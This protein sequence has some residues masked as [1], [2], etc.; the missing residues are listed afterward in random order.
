[1]AEDVLTVP[2]QFRVQADWS[3]RLGS[4]LYSHLLSQAADDY[5]AG[6]PVRELLEPLAHDLRGIA[7]PLQLMAAVHRLVLEGRAPELARFYPSAG[8]SLAIEASWEPFRS[9]MAEQMDRVAPAGEPARSNQRPGALRQPAGRISADRP[10][11]RPALASARNRL[12]RRPKPVLGSIPLRM[13]Q[14]RLGGW[15]DPASPLRLEDV[16]VEGAPPSAAVTV[17]ERSG[18]DPDPVDVHSPEG[19]LTLLACTWPDQL[20]RIRRLEAA[21]GIARSLSYLVERAGAA[22]WLEAR[23]ARPAAGAAT[24]VFHSVVWPYLADSERARVT[25]IIEEAGQAA[26][27]GRAA[28][29]VENGA[30]NRDREEPEVRLRIYPGFDRARHRNYALSMGPPSDGRWS[31]DQRKKGEARG[32]RASPFLRAASRLLEVQAHAELHDAPAGIVGVRKIPVRAGRLAEAGAVHGE[33][34]G[35]SAARNEQQE[36]RPVDRVQRLHAELQVDALGDPGLLHQAEVPLL[37]RRPVEEDSL[38]E[39]A[40]LIRGSDVRRARVE[41]LPT[42][43]RSP[44]TPRSCCRSATAAGS[45]RHRAPCWSRWRPGRPC[46]STSCP[47]AGWRSCCAESRRN[48]S[49]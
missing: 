45:T 28:G 4:P 7:L 25:G 11:H 42:S 48:R 6:G 32:S 34:R 5:E 14:R 39:L 2:E 29:M 10:A 43:C 33:S 13:A 47:E 40:R 27:R 19:R 18:C 36:V 17:V 9:T 41:I 20:E 44:Q 3:R 16:F 21:I 23:L 37:L 31:C 35:D 30:A 15:G 49:G 26:T 8:G 12:Q 24:V 1:M 22:D 38:A 46:G